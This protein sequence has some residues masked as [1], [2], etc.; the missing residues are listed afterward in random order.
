MAAEEL[1]WPSKRTMSIPLK[2][3]TA[4]HFS[5]TA[6][7]FTGAKKQFHSKGAELAPKTVLYFTHRNGPILG[8]KTD[9]FDLQ[10]KVEKCLQKTCFEGYLRVS[11]TVLYDDFVT[12]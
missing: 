6:P 9:H 7:L 12:L 2:T 3:K 5:K 10:L 11:L 4:P 8:A 1:F